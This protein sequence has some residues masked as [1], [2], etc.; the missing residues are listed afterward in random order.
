VD[1]IPRWLN[2]FPQVE[3]AIRELADGAD[4]LVEQLAMARVDALL[5]ETT[6]EVMKPILVAL[7]M[8]LSARLVA[9]LLPGEEA[10]RLGVSLIVLAVFAYSGWITVAALRAA[11]PTIRLWLALRLPPRRFARFLLFREIMATLDAHL[12]RDD[13][14][15]T[16]AARALFYALRRVGRDVDQRALAFRLSGRLVDVALRQVARRALFVMVPIAVGIGYYR[17]AIHPDLI[18]QGSGLG[19]WE[20]PLYPFARL[21]DWLFGTGWAAAMLAT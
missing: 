3:Q 4:E 17:F 11:A 10:G 19:V 20:A 9:P 15:A 18:R 2:P 6:E 1:W 16:L 13:G 14:S 12:R 7:L 21:A 8:L 5:H